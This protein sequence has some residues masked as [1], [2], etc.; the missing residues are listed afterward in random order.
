MRR[1]SRIGARAQ[2]RGKIGLGDVPM[3][4]DRG[5]ASKT[6]GMIVNQSTKL[7][8]I[9]SRFPSNQRPQFCHLHPIQILFAYGY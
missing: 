5:P 1:G 2:N 4:E 9:P 8:L 3:L 7:S 6:E